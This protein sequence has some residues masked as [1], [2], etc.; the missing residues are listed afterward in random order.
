MR[1]RGLCNEAFTAPRVG[2]PLSQRLLEIKAGIAEYVRPENQAI[3]ER[4]VAAIAASRLAENILPVGTQAPEFTLANHNDE[5]ISSKD[6]L[7]RGPL[8]I[9]FFRGR[10]D[11]FCVTELGAWRE[12]YPQLEANGVGLMAISPQTVKHNAF[13]ADQHKL[14]F[15][16]LS[17]AGNQVAR[18]FGLVYTVG[19]EQRKLYKAVFI[20]L[21]QTNGDDSWELPLPATYVIGADGGV[22]YAKAYADYTRRPEI[23]EVLNSL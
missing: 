11:P 8:V 2:V 19:G 4:A 20:N 23:A 6:L 14:R 10:W 7:P 21:P 3:N 22:L 17:D 12:V 15:P 1:W 5:Q 18:Q 13:T 16:V 9:D